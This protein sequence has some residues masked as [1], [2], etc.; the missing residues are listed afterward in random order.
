MSLSFSFYLLFFL[1]FFFMLFSFYFSFPSF[2]WN[3]NIEPPDFVSL[4]TV[5]FEGLYV[6]VFVYMSVCA[7]CLFRKV[8]RLWY[9]FSFETKDIK[10]YNTACHF[11]EKRTHRA[12]DKIH[13]NICIFIYV[14]VQLTQFLGFFFLLHKTKYLILKAQS[15]RQSIWMC[16][17]SLKWKLLFL[18]GFVAFEGQHIYF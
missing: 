10:I 1:S 4:C 3:S 9:H 15:L 13:L 17:W 8:A 11:N 14:Y 6:S 5:F 16:P 18:D 2:H 12:I 7:K